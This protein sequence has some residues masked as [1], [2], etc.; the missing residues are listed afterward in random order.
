LANF[1]QCFGGAQQKS[2]P[3][4]LGLP[5][6]SGQAGTPPTNHTADQYTIKIQTLSLNIIN[7]S[8]MKKIKIK[9]RDIVFFFAGI[10]VAIIIDLVINWE[11][12]K[13]D[14]IDGYNSVRS[15]EIK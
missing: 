10:L 5:E 4:P 12:N 9:K 8:L 3:A 14:F 6:V 15:E 13:N 11:E 7:Q 2:A 1:H